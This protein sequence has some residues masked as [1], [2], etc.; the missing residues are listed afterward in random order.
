MISHV[1]VK[2]FFSFSFLKGNSQNGEVLYYIMCWL[3][4]REIIIFWWKLE[5]RKTQVIA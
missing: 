5:M 1:M 4:N 2:K 3:V